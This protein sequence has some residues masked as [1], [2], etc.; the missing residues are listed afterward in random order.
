MQGK[1]R[2]KSLKVIL[3]GILIPL[4]LVGQIA[5]TIGATKNIAD[6]GDS[7]IQTDLSNGYNAAAQALDNYFWGIEYRMTTMSMTGII[8][9]EM[10]TGDFSGTMGILTGLKGAN[11]VIT[12][13]VFRSEQ[14]D[15]LI[16]ANDT[17]YKSKGMNEVIEDEYYEK[18]KANES[19]WVGPYQDKLTGEM[20]LSEYR[21]VTDNNGKVLGVIGMNINFHDISQ[22]FCEKSFSTTGYSVMLKPD[23]TILSDQMDMSRVHTKTDNATLLEIAAGTEE[24][25][26]TI[27]I[28][29]GTYFYKAGPIP[30]TDWRQVS[31]ISAAEHD[32]VTH[33]S[34]IVQFAIMAG[35]ILVSVILVW[36]F[37]SS[38]TRRL[39]R[40]TVAI[41]QAGEGKLT[42]KVD[43]KKNEN[44]RQDELDM[45][46][47]SYNQM[48]H[49]FSRTIGET[50][51]TLRQLLEQNNALN[52][53]FIRLNTSSE[54][55]NNT[56]QQVAV[57]SEEQARATTTV[58]SETD[59]LSRNIEAVSGLVNTMKDSCTTLKDKTQFGLG[60]VNNLVASSEDTI[61]VTEEIT[62]SINNVDSSSKEI[63]DII[64]LIN[65]ISDQTNL[66]ALNASIEAARAGEA[67]KGFAVVADEIR[68]LA[69][70]SQK[71]TA[72]I[73]S[74]IQ[75]MQ[76]KIGE[77]VEAVTNVNKVMATQSQNVKETEESFQNIFGGVDSLDSLLSEV[78]D[79]NASMVEKKEVIFSS[80]TDL[81]AG[82]EETSASTQEVTNSAHSQAEI[83]RSLNELTDRVAECSDR[84][85]ENLNHFVC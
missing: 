6:Y 36:F 77:T 30:R 28:N 80:M 46:G 41:N 69:E 79:K 5:S 27:Q 73:R 34:M 56:M 37:I 22:F 68:N 55:I 78:E 8:Q 48:I 32:D 82:I 2:G 83:I 3:L 11:D 21:S 7:V 47:D 70:Q 49:D 65:S 64:G 72:D 9:R 19:I 24:M 67:G 14:G 44:K 45:I 39:L 16:V 84:L 33:K 52:E 63:E 58:V 75:T 81:S 71:A 17:D 20:T 59:D 1:K 25:E 51:E 53:S 13:T 38:I 10:S 4:I 29:G 35:V 15:N 18:A 12:G 85:R 23:G 43:L 74:I 40:I 54:D 61:R 57:V 76:S 62:S 31:L 26:G 42:S 66:L 50:K 60:I